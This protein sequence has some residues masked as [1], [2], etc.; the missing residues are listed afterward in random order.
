MAAPLGLIAG[1]G[2]FPF[3]VADAARKAGRRVVAVAIREEADPAVE[4][5][6][7]ETHW[8]SLGQLGKAIDA[9]KAAGVGE[10]VMAGQVKHRQIFSDVVPDLKLLG[11]IAR[12]AF[13]NTDSLLGGVADALERDGIR[14]LPS[15]ALLGD[16]LATR[17]AMTRRAPTKEEQRDIEY[18]REVARHLGHMDLGQTVA[19][20]DRAA[21]A[22]EAMEGT[23]EVIGRAGRIAGAGIVVVKMAKP[24]Q[25]MRFD[26]PVVG[27]A[28]IH[29]IGRAEGR[30]LA[31][32]A[33]KTLLL[34]R[35]AVIAAADAAGI[36][37]WGMEA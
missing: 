11:V 4:G 7:D 28:T 12:L 1:N 21:V 17:G 13:K 24:R 15:V 22:L 10:A 20:K 26:V 16:Q 18:G 2:R 27:E 30:V 6:A 9:L 5:A 34:D 8:V 32:E 25:D 33:G 37:V 3:L 35:P 23:D 29:A 31:V 19:I 36:A 14:L